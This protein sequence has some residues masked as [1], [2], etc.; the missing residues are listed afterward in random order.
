MNFLDYIFELFPKTINY[1][2]TRIGLVRTAN[3]ITLTCSVTAACQSRC[4]TCQIGR[5]Y[6]ENPQIVKRD[7]RLDEIERIFESLGHVYFFNVSGGEP[8]LRQDL[9]KII[10]L[11][12][13]YLMPAIIHLPRHKCINAQTH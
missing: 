12:C 11:A 5:K 4:K 13:K 2:L 8:F 7:L 9:P 6:L 10:E 3:P 1:K